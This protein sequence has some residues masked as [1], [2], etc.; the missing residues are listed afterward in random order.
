MVPASVELKVYLDA[1]SA[2]GVG[3]AVT[4][5]SIGAVL[6]NRTADPLLVVLVT[7]LP[8]LPARSLKPMFRLTD[9]S[10]LLF[11]MV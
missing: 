4:S 3:T 5:S 11:V 2:V 10:V 9:P 6:S 1:L 8:A 7:A